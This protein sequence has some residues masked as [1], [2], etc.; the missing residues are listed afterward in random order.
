[1]PKRPVGLRGRLPVKPP[2]K[3]FNIQYL[4]HYL[5]QPLPP[6]Q[7]PVDV[8]GGITDWGMLGNGPD[9]TLTDSP[10]VGDCTFAGREHYKMAK[11]AA[12]G[13]H[14]TWESSDDLVMEYLAYDGGQDV[15]ANIADLLL[16]WFKTGKILAFAPIDI[17]DPVELDAAIQAFHGGYIG[18]NLTDNDEQQ[19][20]DGQ[21]WDSTD[22]DPEL[23]HCIVK[24]G[25][26]GSSGYDTYVTW[27]ALQKATT[28]W[29][30]ACVEE[31][32]AIVTAED[33]EAAGLNLDAL[34]SDIEALGGRS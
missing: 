8:S 15:G 34:L 31:A 18:I 11:A 21:P 1:M 5:H 19:F 27:G 9:P 17:T 4:G 3:R 29:T 25:A 24:V 26:E 7:Y 2:E 6:P 13:E 14:E 28:E 30:R 32:W 12:Y 33:A 23:G 16:F 10:P 22:P 20:A